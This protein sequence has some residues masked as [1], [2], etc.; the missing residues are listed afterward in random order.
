MIK[1]IGEKNIDDIQKFFESWKKRKLTIFGK[2]CLINILAISK[3]YIQHL[4]AIIQ[5]EHM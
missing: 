2:V 3:L 4:Y 5:K 1:M